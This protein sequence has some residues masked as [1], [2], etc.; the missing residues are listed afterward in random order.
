MSQRYFPVIPALDKEAARK[1]R[2][3]YMEKLRNESLEARIVCSKESREKIA[4]KYLLSAYTHEPILGGTLAAISP[5]VVVN[6]YNNILGED[7]S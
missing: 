1:K 5:E 6:T 2:E 4:S 7:Q 3:A